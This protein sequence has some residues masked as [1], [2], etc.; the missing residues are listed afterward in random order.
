MLDT[1]TPRHDE[2]TDMRK[3]ELK[4]LSLR[5][6][7]ELQSFLGDLIAEKHE[8]AKAEAR[9]KIAAIAEGLGMK[10]QDLM[11]TTRSGRLPPK[12]KYRFPNGATWTGL[13][14]IPTAAKEYLDG[15]DTD[16]KDARDEALQKYLI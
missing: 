7:I 13:G 4:E 15:I 9:E 11:F 6:L 3:S 5:Q 1:L 2:D 8:A 16:D 14:R 12:V 10:P